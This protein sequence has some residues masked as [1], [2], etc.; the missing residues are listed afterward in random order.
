MSYD[1][2]KICNS[3]NLN[4]FAH[5]AK[6]GDCGVLLYWPYPVSDSLLMLEDGKSSTKEAVIEWYSKSSFF[7]HSNFTNMLRFAMDE[8]FKNKELDILDYGGGGGSLHWF[9]FHIF[10]Q[11]QYT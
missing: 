9:A 6:C 7:N 3:T 1:K 8:S 11:P 4:F 10:L 2:C 5:T